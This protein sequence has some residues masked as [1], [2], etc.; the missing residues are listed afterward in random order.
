MKPWS[1][2]CPFSVDGKR[3]GNLYTRH[4]IVRHHSIAYIQKQESR[5]GYSWEIKLKAKSHVRQTL[6]HDYAI[7]KK[8]YDQE[9]INIVSSSYF[10]ILISL[11]RESVC[12]SDSQYVEI[13]VGKVK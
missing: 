6:R 4:R 10:N 7:N 11:T 12:N 8:N 1:L 13:N 3:Y 2:D 9:I 5:P